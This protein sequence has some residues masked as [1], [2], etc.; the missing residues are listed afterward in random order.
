MH[1]RRWGW[2]RPRSTRPAGRSSCRTPNGPFNALAV[3]D[4]P[5]YGAVVGS[6]QGLPVITDANIPTTHGGGRNEDVILVLRVPSCSSGRPATGCRGSS[7]RAG[8][9]AAVDPARASGATRPRR[10]T[11]RKSEGAYLAA[12]KAS[13]SRSAARA[14]AHRPSNYALHI[15]PVTRDGVYTH[16]RLSQWLPFQASSALHAVRVRA[17]R[18]DG[19]VGNRDRP[20]RAEAGVRDHRADVAA[21]EALRAPYYSQDPR[22]LR[23]RSLSRSGSCRTRRRTSP[24]RGSGT[25]GR[26]R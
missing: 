7:V 24:G 14:S 21:G 23:P 25:S 8:E 6:M 12:P 18:R 15:G 11:R 26:T 17:A 4:A 9:R 5:E 13:A 1:P 3:G 20:G 22:D 10:L 16:I 19:R 2:A